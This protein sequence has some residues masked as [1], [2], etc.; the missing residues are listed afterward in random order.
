MYFYTVQPCEIKAISAPQSLYKNDSLLYIES[1][2]SDDFEEAMID[3][4]FNR[5]FDHY[6]E[7][8][9]L[10]L[11]EFANVDGDIPYLLCKQDDIEAIKKR[12][13][14]YLNHQYP[15]RTTKAPCRFHSH[16]SKGE[17][18][19]Y[20]RQRKTTFWWDIDKDF[21]LMFMN[22]SDMARFVDIMVKEYDRFLQK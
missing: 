1:M 17:G 19:M 10:P 13:R 11:D 15:D 22:S 12:L 7:Y 3:N 14:E 20:W 16:Y 9:Y 6:Q 8:V 2:D 4:S 21:M 5:I 18:E